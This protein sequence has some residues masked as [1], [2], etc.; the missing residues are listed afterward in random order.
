MYNLFIIFLIY[1]FCG[2][3][4]E[5]TFKLIQNRKLVN[6]G[7]LVGPLCPIYGFCGVSI[8]L[9]FS[10]IEYNI[11]TV[12]LISI[13][14]CAVFE[15]FV[16]WLLEYLFH[17]RWWDYSHKRFNINGR[18]CLRNLIFFGILGILGVYIFNPK[19][20]ELIDSIPRDYIKVISF[21]AFI[22]LVLD[23]II[24][25]KLVNSLKSF[26]YSVK[27]DAT[28]EIT[29]KIRSILID[30]SI[31]FKRVIVAYPNFRFSSIIKIKDKIS[32]N[33]K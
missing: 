9:L 19:L 7:F 16:S 32:K 5:V 6:R 29:K 26:F 15:Y 12:F 21:I 22:L 24:S 8:Y 27:K 23:T 28:E 17:A 1:S 30:K 18:I 4:M 10:N 20:I 25:V 14:T 2:W 31:Y 33:F 11:F 13:I 3:F